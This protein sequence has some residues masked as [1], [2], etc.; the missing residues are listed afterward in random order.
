MKFTVNTILPLQQRYVKLLQR[1]MN[2]VHED[3]S[4]LSLNEPPLQNT[5]SFPITLN[6]SDECSPTFIR[7]KFNTFFKEDL[8]GKYK[9]DDNIILN[10]GALNAD[11][12]PLCQALRYPIEFALQENWYGYSNSLGHITAR[13]A[14]ADMMDF[15]MKFYD[16]RTDNISLI[17]GVTNGLHTILNTLNT[18]IPQPYRI[19]THL[20]SYS[21]F[22]TTC[23]E[24]ATTDCVIMNEGKFNEREIINSIRRDTKIILLLG[25]MNPLGQMISISSLNNILFE[26]EKRRIY[27]IFDE[28]GAVF[29]EYDFSSLKYS[30]Y[31]IL[32]NSDSKSL[33]VPGLKTGYCVASDEFVNS[34]YAIASN[35]Y[36]SPASLL[37]LFQEFHARF[38][39]FMYKGLSNLDNNALSLFGSNYKLTLPF[40]QLLYQDYLFKQ[41]QYTFLVQKKREWITRKIAHVPRHLVSNYIVPRTGVNMSFSVSQNEDSYKFFLSLL[42]EKKVAL[43]PCVCSGIDKGCWM[44]ISYATSDKILNE[45][46]NRLLGYLEEH[47][48]Y[49]RAL[50]VPIYKTCLIKYGE[51]CKYPSL[52]F[53]GHID[54]V[55][56][57]MKKIWEWSG[58]VMNNEINAL[59]E[60]LSFLHDAGKVISVR[61]AALHRIV[62]CLSERSVDWS[63]Y[64]D[65]ELLDIKSRL[66]SGEEFTYDELLTLLSKEELEYVDLIIWEQ[67]Y[68]PNDESIRNRLFE[69]VGESNTAIELLK[70][71]IPTLNTDSNINECIYAVMDIAD[72]CCDYLDCGQLSIQNV[73]KAFDMKQF[74][75]IKRYAGDSEERKLE[76]KLEFDRARH[77]F[78]TLCGTNC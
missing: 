21:P 20:P 26:C 2:E 47:D 52:N 51:Y 62:C 39:L 37:Y 16:V 5:N 12:F 14:I 77:N 29:P 4:L 23:E 19:L 75:V 59:C 57:C 25:D 70:G 65:V 27:L 3:E 35:T 8:Y 38:R 43:F 73:Y 24:F 56:V 63:I 28:A 72:K 46:F 78:I 41:K 64:S 76:I 11:E 60:N 55:Y 10:N 71:N 48:S 6:R 50:H 67:Q 22:L 34:F 31:F 53:F 44:R 9:S 69:K 32:L 49:T 18:I 30:S 1:E 15:R 66:I 42:Q 68:S 33:G 74:Y 61:L 13:K 36:G 17:N 7:E 40:L 45:G 54:N 58:R